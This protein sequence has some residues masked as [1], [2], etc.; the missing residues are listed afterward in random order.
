MDLFHQR[1]EQSQV[2]SHNNNNDNTELGS[3]SLTESG[4][5]VIEG[6]CEIG[7]DNLEIDLGI[8]IGFGA[9]DSTNC[10]FSVGNIEDSDIDVSVDVYGN[11][12]DDNDD[13]FFVERRVSGLESGGSAG[14]GEPFGNGLEVIGFESDSDDRDENDNER[15][16]LT[17][18]LHSVNEDD[19]DASYNNPIFW[20]SFQLEDHRE[21]NEDL[22]WEEV[23]G[24]L[25]EREVMSMYVDADNDD[26]NSISLSISPITVPEDVVTVERV[27]EVENLE[28]QV[29]LNS[30]NLETNP[31][32]DSFTEHYF[33][34]H[35]DY[36]YTAEY[37]MMFGQF[38][39]NENA[40]T[41]RPPASKI[42]LKQLPLVVLTQ[43]YIEKNDAFCAICKDEMNVG[44]KAKQLPCTHRYHG[45]CIVPWLRIR[46]TCPVC[47]HELPTD[48]AEYERRRN[49]RG[50]RGR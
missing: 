43:E 50:A 9:P 13:D 41:G 27:G 46:N 25:E 17:I 26:E 34:D 8:G 49:Q 38:T 3:D 10:G 7:M 2:I 33:G 15:E 18:D 5:G 37:E 35:E 31:D 40:L 39:E 44:E 16:R 32:L 28:W 6:N 30:D 4:F 24:G 45:D 19:D 42:V 11:E 14:T 20:D 36:I 22:E 1:V 12:D 47:R 29:L 21:T 48:D 23:D